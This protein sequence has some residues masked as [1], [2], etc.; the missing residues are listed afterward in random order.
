MNSNFPNRG[1]ECIILLRTAHSTSSSTTGTNSMQAPL[2]MHEMGAGEG[3]MYEQN[4][5]PPQW[6]HATAHSFP[7]SHLMKGRE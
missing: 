1:A 7:S 2:I 3:I 5:S 4:G 6:P